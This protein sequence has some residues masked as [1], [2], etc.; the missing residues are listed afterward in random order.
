MKVREAT[1]VQ[2]M[3]DAEANARQA[4]AA[5]GKV[6]RV[7]YETFCARDETYQESAEGQ[8]YEEAIDRMDD[9][10]AALMG[11]SNLLR[12]NKEAK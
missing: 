5:T 1:L 4:L 12:E 11:A 2:L 10:L 9:A 7:M 8:D 3:K 6:R